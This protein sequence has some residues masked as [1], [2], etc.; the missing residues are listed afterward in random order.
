MLAVAI[1]GVLAVIA[2]GQ[3]TQY[4]ERALIF[5]AVL[6]IGAM[7]S[8]IARFQADNRVLPSTL[9][10]IGAALTND[11][12]GNPYQ[13]LSHEDE[14]GKAGFRKDKRIVPINTDYDLYSMGKDGASVPPLTAKVS[15]DDI[16]RASDGRFIGLVSDFDP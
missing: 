15:R 16:V 4:R 11:P 14:K 12:W 10:D 13:Y 9:A 5:Q 2:S 7:E 1:V 8:Q 6:D 3:Y